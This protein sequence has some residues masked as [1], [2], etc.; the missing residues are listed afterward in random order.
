MTDPRSTH[1]FIF[2]DVLTDQHGL[3]PTRIANCH[4]FLKEQKNKF[5]FTHQITW[6]F[7]EP[8]VNIIFRAL[9]LLSQRLRT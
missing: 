9:L 7:K 1:T 5:A 2:L 6:S 3:K 8:R 4:N